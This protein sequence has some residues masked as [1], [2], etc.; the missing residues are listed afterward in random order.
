MLYLQLTLLILEERGRGGGQYARMTQNTMHMRCAKKCDLEG[1][2]AFLIVH[3]QPLIWFGFVC[4][5]KCTNKDSQAK[6]GR[7]SCMGH[8]VHGK[9]K[10]DTRCMCSLAF[11]CVQL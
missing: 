5:F 10:N 9:I 3:M 4:I 1:N 7:Q 8:L 11:W 2:M 6:I